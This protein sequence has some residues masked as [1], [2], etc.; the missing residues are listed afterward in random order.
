M[1]VS[2]SGGVNPKNVLH[3]DNSQWVSRQIASPWI[4]L[5]YGPKMAYADEV[6]LELTGGFG[7][8]IQGS[9][10]G[11]SFSQPLA[12]INDMPSIGNVRRT[13]RAPLND[14]KMK[15]MFFEVFKLA[16]KMKLMFF[17][18]FKLAKMIFMFFEVFKLAKNKLHVF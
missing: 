6:V 4:Q 7:G 16:K 13:F 5:D 17:E 3:I 14:K 2:A 1:K 12:I 9:A 8:I 10:D 11:Q 15:F 18:F